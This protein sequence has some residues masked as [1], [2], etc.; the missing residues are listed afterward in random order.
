MIGYVMVGT[1]DLEKAVA[2][3]DDLL[4]VI[5]AKRAMSD[6]GRFVGW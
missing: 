5:G 2:F 1:N 4:G 6:P 3:F